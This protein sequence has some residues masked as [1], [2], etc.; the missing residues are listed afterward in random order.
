MSRT[1]TLNLGEMG[2]TKMETVGSTPLAVSL[3]LTDS[4]GGVG[5]LSSPLATS[6]GPT[7][8]S[9]GL[10]PMKTKQQQGPISQEGEYEPSLQTEMFI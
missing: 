10:T 7:Q 3:L 2:C 5:F 1:L 6:Q 9:Q 8:G 4:S